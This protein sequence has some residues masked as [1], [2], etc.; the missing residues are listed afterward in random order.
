MLP[1]NFSPCRRRYG[2]QTMNTT[3]PQRQTFCFALLLFCVLFISASTAH[4][5]SAAF[6][7]QGRLVDNAASANGT[8]NME[9]SLYD[10]VASGNQIGSTLTNTNVQVTNGAFTVQLDFSPATPFATGA[11]R[12]LSITV[13]HPAD[14]SYTPLA[15]RQPITATPYA[16]RSLSTATSDTA[17]NALSLGNAA[18]SLY[19]LTNDLRLTDPR[20]PTAGSGNYIQ[21][22]PAA[23][24]T[25]SNFNIDGTGAANVF[26]ATT[27]FNI[28]GSRVLSVGSGNIFA[29]TGTGTANTTGGDNAFVGTNAGL[30]NATGSNN[31]FFGTDAGRKN[32]ASDNSFFGRSAGFANTTGVSNS[33]F[34][35]DA[36]RFNLSGG[37]NAFFGIA[38]GSS[39]TLGGDNSFV[40]AR[41]GTSNLIGG[42]NSFFGA[43]AGHDNTASNN[44]FFGRSAGFANTIGTRNVFF[45]EDSGRF[46]LAGSG[47]SFFGIQAGQNN[48]TGAN[49]TAVGDSANVGANNLNFATALGSGATVSTSNTI[50]L[51]RAADTV[52]APN[53]LQV[54]ALGAAGGTTLCRNAS[55]QISICTAGAFGGNFIQNSTV[56]Q[57]TSNFNVSGSG[58][59]GA[60]LSANVVNSATN[61]QI[62]GANVFS[63][64]NSSSVVAGRSANHTVLAADST[65]FGYNTGAATTIFG[66]ANTFIGS[67]AGESNTNGSSNSFVGKQAGI[68]NSTGS[69]NSFFGSN[70]GKFNNAN[71][72][73][74]FGVESGFLGVGGT[75]NSFFGYQTGRANLNGD[76]NS[77]FGYQAGKTTTGG[78]NT[79]VG[80]KAGETNT[81]G[82]ANTFLGYNS[83]SSSGN[84]NTLI[85][86]STYSVSG[87][88]NTVIGVSAGSSS[89]DFSTAIGAGASSEGHDNTAIG[90]GASVEK[91]GPMFSAPSFA[92]A[93]GAGAVA[94]SSN[95][96]VLG[97]SND[98]VKVPGKL[99][100]DSDI[101]AADI[102]TQTLTV[103]G[104]FLKLTAIPFGTNTG[105]KPLCRNSNSLVSTCLNLTD[106]FSSESPQQ[107]AEIEKQAAQIEA[108][109]KQLARQQILIEGL[110]KIV[111]SQN[112]QAEVCKEMK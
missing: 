9:F 61:F 111:C 33:F 69:S 21:S 31:S 68:F 34:G 52:V 36:G 55:N 105:N 75:G 16:I 64:P 77:F 85:G 10:A 41:A 96:V 73:S 26:N 92:T 22:A 59:L 99:S 53:L 28:G 65:F 20:S 51:G 82:S 6:T 1:E 106:N 72:N 112:T 78:S 48:T 17:T 25:N 49:N 23:Q 37:N 5:Q 83:G 101:F 62:G 110:R 107:N 74:Y 79:F 80:G 95:S 35:E 40:G 45:G 24:Q 60:G 89:G 29:G 71:E 100:V 102:E 32:T 86:V 13:K 88:S 108:Q 58:T 2:E 30:S 54:G 15:P 18:A 84:S 76:N 50:V 70:A 39:N 56:Q 4:A 57:P 19:V 66:Q 63:T 43:D 109:Q 87:N 44:S 27:Q 11:N 3:Q 93:V 91:F 98:F 94:N 14:A 38:A 67:E 47:N 46:N 8:Y 42:N 104:G 81:S 103:T 90:S 97:R 12:F 7:Y